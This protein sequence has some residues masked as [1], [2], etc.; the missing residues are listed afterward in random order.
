VKGEGGGGR[1]LLETSE[2]LIYMYTNSVHIGTDFENLSRCV[3][4]L[5]ILSLSLLLY[6][7]PAQIT[8]ESPD[9]RGSWR[10]KG[11][12]TV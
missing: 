1:V 7:E 5:S 8:P 9:R 12:I 11:P 10:K 4:S 3:A 6:I 2:A